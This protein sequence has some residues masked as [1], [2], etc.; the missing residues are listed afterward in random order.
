[1]EEMKPKRK[2][3]DEELQRR[4][5][6]KKIAPKQYWSH[7]INY[8]GQYGTPGSVSKEWTRADYLKSLQDAF[9][10]E[11]L[12][13]SSAITGKHNY[14]TD[15]LI[16]ALGKDPNSEWA[17]MTK[18]RLKKAT[19]PPTAKNDLGDRDWETSPN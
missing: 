14:C 19:L 16:P 2:V 9:N 15:T 1:M 4:A 12:P 17:G 5:E 18:E 7:Y 3:S 10:L 8:R 6:A 11:T 13:S